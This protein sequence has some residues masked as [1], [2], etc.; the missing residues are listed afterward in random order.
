[1]LGSRA[2]WTQPIS[3][4]KAIPGDYAS[5]TAAFT[6]LTAK[7]VNGPV[8]LELQSAYVPVAAEISG[9]IVYSFT[10]G[11]A[12]NTITVRP[13]AGAN[14]LSIS[15]S[16]NTGPMFSISGGRNLILDGRPGGSG[17]PVS[18]T[19]TA[20]DLTIANSNAGG[21]TS[22]VAFTSDA[23]FNTVQHCQLRAATVAAFGG[24]VVYFGS[25]T[26]GNSNNTV[27][28]ND[29]RESAGGTPTAG[30]LCTSAKNA[31]NAIQGNNIYNFFRNSASDCY[32]MYLSSAGDGWTIADNS[33][34]QTANR[35]GPGNAYMYGINL[36]TGN[37]HLVSGNYIGGQA[38]TCG[39]AGAPLTINGTAA[40]Y[41]FAGIISVGSTTTANSLQGNTIA[42]I[43][44]LT[45]SAGAGTGGIFSGIY[46]GTGSVNIGTVTG[47]NIGTLALPITCSE[48]TNNGGVLNGIS[49]NSSASVGAVNI[50]QNTIQNIT[51]VG[52]T[53][54]VGA[55]VKGV[56]VLGGTGI[57][58]SRNRIFNLASTVVS[59]STAT[60]FG[61]DVQPGN[62]VVSTITNN[63]IGDLRAPAA[64][65]SAN[66][67]IGISLSS[68][69]A[70]NVY[71]NTVNLSASSTGTA[72]GSSA[73]S[74]STAVNLD[75]R[76]NILVNT[77]TPGSASGLTVALRRSAAATTTNFLETSNNNLLY[78]GAAAANK[79]LYSDGTAA[80]QTLTAYKN[81]LTT[82]AGRELYAVTELP[83]FQYTAVTDAA[84]LAGYLHIAA[85][86][87]TQV[88]SGGQP[89]AGLATDYDAQTRATDFPDIGADE[90]SFLLSDKTQPA[91][92]FTA[93]GNGPVAASRALGSVVIADPSGV[94][95]D[96]S[97]LATAGPYV[98]YRKGTAG[99]YVQAA[100]TSVSGTGNTR[101]FGFT[102]D[103]ALVGG[104][105]AG[106]VIQYYLAAQ[107]AAATPNGGT[108][109][110]NVGAI[111]TN[112]NPPGTTSAATFTA[113]PGQYTI[114]PT[115]PATVYVGT[116]PGGGATFYPSLTKAGGLFAALNA[117]FV[118][119]NVTAVVNANLAGEDGANAL[120]ALTTDGGTYSLTIQSDGTARTVVGTGVATA[121][122]GGLIRFNGVQ[123]VTV[124]GG[125]G[126]ARN[127]LF[128][129]TTTTGVP[130]FG[131]YND[132]RFIT[133]NNLTIESNNVAGPF[134]TNPGTVGF[135]TG[136]SGTGGNRN[137][138]LDGCEIRNRSDIAATIATNPGLAVYSGTTA[139]TGT[140]SNNTLRNCN[141]FDFAN[142]GLYLAT[143]G[144]GDNWTVGG[145]GAGNNFYLTTATTTSAVS[146]VYVNAG[147][148]H[149]ITY[150]NLYTTGT[151]SGNYTGI[152][153]TGGNGLV[154]SNNT[155]G[156]S[157]AGAGGNPLTASGSGQFAAISLS[158]GAGSVASPYALV[159]NNVIR[160]L[161]QT[162]LSS[163]SVYGIYVLGGAV[164]VSG[165]TVG[166]PGAVAPAVGFTAASTTV[167][168]YLSFS[169]TASLVNNNTVAGMT[170]VS[171]AAPS[172]FFSGIQLQSG[173]HTVSGNTVSDLRVASGAGATETLYGLYVSGSTAAS[174]Q[175][176]AVKR[177]QVASG[178]GDN[179]TLVALYAGGG[180]AHAVQG[181]TIGVGTAGDGLAN[182]ARAAAGSVQT[183]G[184]QAL[185]GTALVA[186]NTISDMGNTNT[187]PTTNST[188][189]TVVYGIS[190]LNVTG[191]LVV[192]NN[193]VQNLYNAAPYNTLANVQEGVQALAFRGSTTNAS[194]QN[195][196]VALV[197]T[198]TSNI[199]VVGIANA[200]TGTGNTA[201]Y[202]SVY[203]S[204][205][206]G[207]GVKTYA[208]RHYT[209]V[210][211]A[212]LLRLRNNVLVNERTGGV[213][214][215]AIGASSTLAGAAATVGTTNAASVDSD[216]NDL[217]AAENTAK[218][219][220][221]G[222]TAL[223]FGT[224]TPAVGWLGQTGNPDANSKNVRVKFSD[225]AAGNLNL[226]A[227][228]NCQLDG[229]GL[230]IAGVDGEYDN[231]AT[232]RQTTPDLGAD[233]FS[234]ATQAAALASTT[235]QT[236]CPGG[237]G[238][239]TLSLAGNGGPFT[240]VYSNGTANTTLTGATNAQTVSVPL[241]GST[242]TY[243]LVSATDAYGCALS[244]TPASSTLTLS[245]ATTT[246]WNGSA[247]TDW[248]A[249]ANWTNCVPGSNTDAT[250]AAGASNYP[251]LNSGIAAVRTLAIASGASLAQS[252]GTLKVYG[253]LSNT[254]TTSL[255][256]GT[257]ALLGTSPQ[258]TGLS[259]FYALEV[260]LNSGT[261]ALSNPTSISSRLTMTQ[262]V[263]NTSGYALTLPAG[264]T[265]SETETSYVLGTVSAPGRTLVAGT[266][267]NFGGIGLV[268]TPATGSVSP[269]LT[270]VVRT[271]GTAL[272]GAGTS[273]SIKRYFDI[274]P[275]VNTGLNVA[276][277]FSYFTHELNGIPSANLALFKS[278]TTTAGPWANQ[279]PITAT[280]NTISKAGI[281]DFSIWTL[282]NSAN[283][284]PVEL[285]AF[286][287]ERHGTSAALAWTTASEKNN[288]GFEVQVSTDGRNFRE[289]GF[290]AGAGSSTAA[291]AYAFSDQEAGKAGLRYYRLRQL[292][293]NGTATFS[294]VRALTFGP[295]EATALRL[296]AAPNPFRQVLTLTV[297]VPLGT[298]AAPAQLTL[299]DAAGRALLKQGTATLVA[300]PNTVELP[301][302]A[303]LASG[304]YFVH[305]ALPG[306]PAQ[307]LKVVKE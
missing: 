35:V 195:N 263:L 151:M 168:I 97:S 235:A 67:V 136:A 99:N 33:L 48:V 238:T 159:Q 180:G 253:N 20:N 116:D 275:A 242:T 148:G 25:G 103:Y 141:V 60:C 291:H 234:S 54:S 118:T 32:G 29:L 177:L 189:V 156:G 165:N 239:L 41:K 283:P 138:V 266:A 200:A 231:P 126:A 175:G 13:A 273:V 194:F 191:P 66:A 71:Y 305:L 150:N 11:S 129:T 112:A 56:Y 4:T 27:Q 205:I 182:G 218:Q 22:A 111:L 244:V 181:N 38:P 44:W 93:L 139:T 295:G 247:S 192:R 178:A 83:P 219:G 45:T 36:A 225:P 110:P 87:A 51:A 91:I 188:N 257:V 40:A 233:E 149:V 147:A 77:S 37:S 84:S 85:G 19:I 6:D 95:L 265:L 30:V 104:V 303:G 108:F 204:G 210:S 185:S 128:R 100:Y 49:V 304:V 258:V 221:N 170:L 163:A 164:N 10:G 61:L 15:S 109:V 78:G 123:N 140:N 155:I 255:T 59:N 201:Y 125:T 282:G 197:G 274:Q 215:F 5:L 114:V 285:T 121:N 307:H 82:L 146:P 213:G 249:A 184:I 293:L 306:Q 267:E 157:Q 252:G 162:S 196:Q 289:L 264:S 223:A 124:S 89:V 208:L 280:G 172:S 55:S 299:T 144:G 167:G 88:E 50:S 14:G 120:N 80:V 292:D 226:D 250:I 220:E 74:A 119:Q 287:A 62:S 176:N 31:A 269:G 183:I 153:V 300:G 207:A 96:N 90:G 251:V 127:L 296:T 281:A 290:V 209:T 256:G 107:D 212:N 3:G 106:D 246:T 203:V 73:L 122:A 243:T 46:I 278:V 277:D 105:V 131:Y 18:G 260:N 57:V 133:L 16:T 53:A 236:V 63:L 76:N 135:Y 94:G 101:I 79:L 284:L 7:G 64:N 28:Y 21:G 34:Y 17:S 9:G 298:A 23:T 102:L 211:T 142:Y 92:R 166:D 268:L 276:M 229:A 206:S 294:P 279:S 187:A 179:A 117:G 271:T 217:Y 75:L 158:A 70:A 12:T 43:A 113:T 161:A 2:G 132:A 115:I 254:G 173:G 152:N 262:G 65:S 171:G 47:N 169:A 52:G 199:G 130:V 222:T 228:T 98:Y 58:L 145:T 240:V 227:T 237:A 241:V 261:V 134:G 42:N 216:Y 1:M 39:T 190:A 154:I 160:N 245:E 198:A 26:N 302:L 248:F 224:V 86:T 72:F 286:T 230:A 174:I 137:N 272:T 202:N 8:V 81:L 259:T 24:A 68:T 186:G 297:D 232:S 270:P 214:N 143:T 69:S 193:R 288:R 301:E